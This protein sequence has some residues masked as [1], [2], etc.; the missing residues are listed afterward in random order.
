MKGKK[1]PPISGNGST[2]KLLLIF[3]GLCGVSGGAAHATQPKLT[4]FECTPGNQP[5]LPQ[6]HVF[7]KMA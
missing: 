3:F 1:L 4:A 6:K 7:R 2:K 5:I